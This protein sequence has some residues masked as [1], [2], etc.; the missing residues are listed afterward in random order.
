MKWTALIKAFLAPALLL[1]G[2]LAAGCAGAEKVP[3]PEPSPAPV[4]AAQPTGESMNTLLEKARANGRVRVIVTVEAGPE[5]TG[6]TLD[7]TAEA[8][9]RER[10]A[11]AQKNLLAKLA[12]YPIAN[13]VRFEYSPAIAL[14]VNAETLEYLGSLP[15]VTR[16]EED[17][18]SP[19]LAAP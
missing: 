19:P 13:V 8:A 12:K 14:D 6:W 9:Q 18:P 11:Q 3:L 4:Q 16:I 2:L 1:A 17:S 7:P 10:A 5:P 15:E